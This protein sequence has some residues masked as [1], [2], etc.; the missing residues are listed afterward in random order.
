MKRYIDGT[1][2]KHKWVQ[3]TL[4]GGGCVP[5]CLVTCVV[6]G[7]RGH[8]RSEITPRPV[9]LL[10]RLRGRLVNHVLQHTGSGGAA[11]PKPHGMCRAVRV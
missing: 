9:M 8:I 7:F 4:H 5:A 10:R 3:M 1:R 11:V 2:T 6:R